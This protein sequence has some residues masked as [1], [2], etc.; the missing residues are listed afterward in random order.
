[1]DEE[2]EEDEDEEDEEEEGTALNSGTGTVAAAGKAKRPQ[3]FAIVSRN[4]R[5]NSLSRQYSIRWKARVSKSPPLR[6]N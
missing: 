5:A 1:M 3:F 4:T 6:S 2:D